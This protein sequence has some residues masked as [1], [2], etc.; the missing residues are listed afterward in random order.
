MNTSKW[1]RIVLGGTLGLLIIIGA[2]TA[3]IDPF[4]H[5]HLPLKG[6]EYP[7]LDERYQNDGIARHFS[8]DAI[9]TGTS[10]TQNFKP[11][12]FDALWDANAVKI[13]FSGASY[14]EV[15]DNIRRAL[16]YNGGVKYI[17]R[18]I[19]GSRLIYP[20][21]YDEYTGYPDYLYDNNPWNDVRY[22]LNKEVV[23]KT[24]AV[25]NYTLA[26]NTTPT[27]D[28][29]GSW[30]RYMTFG[31]EAVL[32]SCPKWEETMEEYVLSQEDILMIQENVEKNVLQTALEH[33]EITFYLFFPPYSIC[34]WDALVQTKQ[35]NAQLEAEEMAVR[36][37]TGIDNIHLYAFADNIGMVSNLDNY[38]DSLH[39]GEWINSDILNWIHRGE[40][41]L[42]EDNYEAYFDRIHQLYSEYDYSDLH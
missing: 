17:L 7:L 14:K 18:S 33:P 34:Y 15:N 29:Y 26:G 16:E 40:H 42:T 5:Y 32:R 28:E 2:A 13:A 11:S 23:P 10:M 24:L 27:L 22:L 21:D 41:E 37:L 20:A 38:A 6:L 25:V 9:I 4:L 12:E 3:V 30:N 1:N 31:R 36:M 35:L 19:D 8:Y 39:Y